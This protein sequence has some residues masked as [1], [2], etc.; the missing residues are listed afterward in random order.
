MKLGGG[1]HPCDE[2]LIQ[3]ALHSVNLEALEHPKGK[4]EVFQPSEVVKM[5]VSL[6]FTRA[7]MWCDHDR[8]CKMLTPRYQKTHLNP[9]YA[10]WEKVPLLLP[11]D[12]HNELLGLGE[13]QL[14]VASVPQHGRLLHHYLR[15][16]LP[17]LCHL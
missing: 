17:R 9:I 3:D 6:S 1:P 11:G 10:E 12:V 5:P 14:K 13:P 16:G 2:A 4:L 8:S 15:S 7:L